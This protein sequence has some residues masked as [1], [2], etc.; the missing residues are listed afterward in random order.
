MKHSSYLKRMKAAAFRAVSLEPYFNS[1]RLQN[2]ET[3][4]WRMVF[5]TAVF[6]VNLSQGIVT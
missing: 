5:I 3:V 4:K 2:F 1:H 6:L